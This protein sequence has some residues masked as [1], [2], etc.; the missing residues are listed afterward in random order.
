MEKNG[1][2]SSTN[3]AGA[4]Y[5]TG[6]CD[7]QCPRDV[8]FIKGEANVLDWTPTDPSSG[9]GHYGSCCTEVRNCEG[10]YRSL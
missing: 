10:A 6:Y 8:K 7:A 2:M 5:G 9:K 4:K 3:R 1:G